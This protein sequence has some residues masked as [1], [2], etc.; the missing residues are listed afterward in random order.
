MPSWTFYPVFIGTTVSIIGL[1]HF[2]LTQRHNLKTRTLSELATTE[3]KLLLRFRNI[4]LFCGPFFAVSMFAFIVPRAP[5]PAPTLVLSLGIITGEMLV[6]VIPARKNTRKIHESLAGLMAVTMLAMPYVLWF[7]LNGVY[8]LAE[9]IL[10]IFM[11]VLAG[12]LLSDT[13]RKNFVANELLFIFASH[14]SYGGGS[15]GCA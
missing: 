3:E 9:T 2:G 8:R 7:S 11:T 15:V 5:H 10:A 1:S 14:I 6:G 13:Y 12:L 4:L